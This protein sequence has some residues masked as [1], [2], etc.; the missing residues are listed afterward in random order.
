M[1]PLYKLFI[2]AIILSLPQLN[3][4]QNPDNST[5]LQGQWQLDYNTTIANIS[6]ESQ[7]ILNRFDQAQLLSLENAFKERQLTFQA[8]GD[9]LRQLTDGSQLSGTW[10]FNSD[11]TAILIQDPGNVTHTQ[12]LIVLTATQLVISLPNQANS[13]PL[14]KDLYFIKN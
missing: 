12:Q 6:T 2:I 10:S 11:E 4:G 5:L 13:K 14:I 7:S 9:Y 3:M 8:N 1:K